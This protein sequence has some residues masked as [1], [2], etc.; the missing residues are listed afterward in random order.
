MLFPNP[1]IEKFHH[2]YAAIYY[3]RDKAALRAA[4]ESIKVTVPAGH[5]E[6]PKLTLAYTEKMSEFKETARLEA[7][8]KA[9]EAAE[10]VVG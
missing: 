7:E 8:K 10:K 4:G 9:K 1:A 2:H 3:S 6:L 5:E